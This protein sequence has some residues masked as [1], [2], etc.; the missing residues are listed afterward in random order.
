MNVIR[1]ARAWRTGP[2]G[3]TGNSAWA[4]PST[5]THTDLENTTS[6]TAATRGRRNRPHA[7]RV[8]RAFQ[9]MEDQHREVGGSRDTEGQG[10]HE[11]HVHLLEGDAEDDGH[12]AQADGRK[13]GHAQFF[14]LG[15]LALTD[16]A[17]VD[18]VEMAA[19]PASARPDTTAGM[20][21]KAT[22]DRK[23]SS[24]LPPTAL[25][26][27]MAIMLPPPT[28]F[29]ADLAAFEELGVLADDDDGRKAH[30]Q[31]TLKK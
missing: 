31:M 7:P 4:L 14:G 29:A 16:H 3:R 10:H 9:Y 20:V 21:A 23:P 5:V 12:E 6:S 8:V 27:C 24:R 25:A 1:K 30:Q 28:I 26:R 13:A 15:R 22:A 11:R 19:A 17:G 2:A 18:V